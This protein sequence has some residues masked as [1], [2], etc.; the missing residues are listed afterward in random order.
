M[1]YIHNVVWRVRQAASKKVMQRQ[2]HNNAS[3]TL[4]MN[5]PP[6]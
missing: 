4:R 1:S 6:V 2:L 3:Q 5:S